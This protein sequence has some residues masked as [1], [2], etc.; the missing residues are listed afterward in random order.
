MRMRN[1]DAPPQKKREKD[2]PVHFKQGKRHFCQA[3][4]K[5]VTSVSKK[6]VL[7]R[8]FSNFLTDVLECKKDT[9]VLKK[10]KCYYFFLSIKGNDRLV[11]K[12]RTIRN[13]IVEGLHFVQISLQFLR[14]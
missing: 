7:S 8:M 10:T 5:K 13:T 12:L 11:R 14:Q 2:T 4:K 3:P 9:Y 1:H 6:T